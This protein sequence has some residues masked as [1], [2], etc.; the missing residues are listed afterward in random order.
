MKKRFIST[1][2]AAATLA[3][4]ALVSCGGTKMPDKERVD[5]VYKGEEVSLKQY[6]DAVGQARLS[7]DTISMQGY[8]VLNRDTYETENHYLTFSLD[9][10]LISD[11]KLEKMPEY[12]NMMQIFGS[13][14]G[15]LRAVVTT[16]DPEKDE[17]YYALYTLN[18]GK[19]GEKLVDDLV[20]YFETDTSESRFGG[21]GG[22]GRWIDNAL[23]DAE[24]HLIITSDTLIA[25]L[26]KDLK[27]KLFEV[28][29]A[30][31]GYIENIDVTSDGKVMVSFYDYTRRMDTK[32]AR[33]D[34]EKRALTD[35]ITMPSGDNLRNG[36][37]SFAPDFDLYCNTRTGVYGINMNEDGTTGEPELLLDFV[38]SDLIASEVGSLLVLDR[39]NMIAFNHYYDEKTDDSS[40]SMLILKHVPDDEVPEKYVLELAVRYMSYDLP[41]QVVRFNR[42]SD[43]YRVKI[44][45]WD[46][47]DEENENYDLGEE[48]L[49]KRILSGDTPDMIFLRN[50]GKVKNWLSAG[51]FTDLN[52]LME[53][54][55]SFD[56]SKLYENVLAKFYTNGKL[57]QFPTL[58][59]IST[60]SGKK[61][62]LPSD[63]WTPEQFIE[64]VKSLP[65]G[66]QI[67]AYGGK[68]AIFNI[69]TEATMSHFI[70]TKKGTCSFDSDE[71]RNI[72]EF[73]NSFP[74]TISFL[75]TLT[76]DEQKDYQNDYM[77]MYRDDR[78]MLNNSY[79]STVGEMLSNEVSMGAGEELSYI[80]YPT[81]EGSGALLSVR[82]SYAIFQGS[83]LK[84]GAWEFVKFM[85]FGGD[86]SADR[87][88]DAFPISRAGFEN[89]KKGS[90]KQ[91]FFFNYN[92][93][94]S[95]W[96]GDSEVNRE[97][98]DDGIY[99]DV[100][101]E[102]LEKIEKLIEGATVKMLID[103]TVQEMIHEEISMYFAGDKSLDETVKVIQS[104]VGTYVAEK[105]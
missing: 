76:A 95:S 28:Q 10:T 39:E 9:G 100:Y 90:M 73:S 63:G 42:Q 58:Y 21:R 48:M 31:D 94:W 96:G 4:S 82:A 65:E 3:A 74:E 62:N 99:R 12:T 59:T 22:S 77:K 15:T 71:F 30:E 80:G 17:A 2:L 68:W 40:V 35:E 92:G 97:E 44:S 104:R 5:H 43:E 56:K 36:S 54:D 37:F 41:S 91:H 87:W 27:T 88:Y 49:E 86:D 26:D 103:D 89:M 101:P 72:L 57:Y 70:D 67:M 8:K 14:D 1:L 7:G 19:L 60:L 81:Y 18:D 53:K 33:I 52:K 24:G 20:S 55:S 51:S 78:V 23:M 46:Q 16:Y 38:N 84:D 93:G 79:I 61:S 45:T 29:V 47:V 75:G 83:Q 6:T 98:R 13:P 32:V 11:Q 64:Y 34:I 66:R 85:I 50:F 25:V 105:N 102:D 69:L